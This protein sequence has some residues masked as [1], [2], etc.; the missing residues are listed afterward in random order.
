MCVVGSSR[1]IHAIAWTVSAEEEI[2]SAVSAPGSSLGFFFVSSFFLLSLLCVVCVHRKRLMERAR[3]LP[4]EVFKRGKDLENLLPRV[5]HSCIVDDRRRLRHERIRVD[6]SP[7]VPRGD[8][9][10]LRDI[11]EVV[12][13]V[14]QRQERKRSRRSV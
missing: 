5:L 11:D 6:T 12:A 8:V 10:E 9:L 4:G 7:L 2:S 1:R 14:R 13:S 3:K